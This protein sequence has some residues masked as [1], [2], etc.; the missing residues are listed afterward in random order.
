MSGD[1][2]SASAEEDPPAMAA[3]DDRTWQSP[4]ISFLKSLARPAATDRPRRN[5]LNPWQR[6]PLPA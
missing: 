2:K 6:S 1:A 4:N 3:M 5:E